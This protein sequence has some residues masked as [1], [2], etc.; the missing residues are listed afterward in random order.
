MLTNE[1]MAKLKATKSEAEWNKVC[2]EIKAERNGTYPYD[3][4]SKVMMS[5]VFGTI[6]ASWV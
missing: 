3:W 1:E 4:W 5:G 6:Q 2:D